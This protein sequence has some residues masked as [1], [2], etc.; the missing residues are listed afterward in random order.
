MEK[1]PQKTKK[2]AALFKIFY[3]ISPQW[4]HCGTYFKQIHEAT[5][6]G[7]NFHFFA[8]FGHWSCD[9]QPTT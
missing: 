6:Q 5:V 3:I 7:Y 4:E 1:N 8:I 9:Q 2:N